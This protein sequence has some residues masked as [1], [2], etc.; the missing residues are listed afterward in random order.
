MR[1]HRMRVL[2]VGLGAM[3]EPM[4]RRLVGDAQVSVYDVAQDRREAVAAAIGAEVV[5]DP[6]LVIG[7][8]EVVIL[9]LPNSDIVDQV[10]S[11][12][13][14]A[15]RM[16]AGT[17]VVDMGSSDPFRTRELA[18]LLQEHGVDLVDAPVSGGRARA[19]SG[20]LTIMTGGSAVAKETVAPLL[21]AL[22]T[23]VIDV[24]VTGNGHAM[25][26]LN[27]LLS[28]TGLLAA[29]EVIA[30]GQRFGLTPETML[31][32]INASTGRNH[33][34]QVK[35]AE[36]ILSRRFDAGFAIGLMVKDLNTAGSLVDRVLPEGNLLSQVIDEW[37]QAL[38]HLEDGS[39]DH[40]AVARWVETVSGA[41][42]TADASLGV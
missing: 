13:G 19:I 18:A 35:F 5:A 3:G 22:G 15:A 2:V 12:S 26:A 7:D 23:S 42:L 6:S 20:E 28:A 36:F 24:G 25:K 14:L 30:S 41:Q 37:A 32:V 39:A 31:A 9:M 4:A 1:T 11:G 40:T 17:V 38:E 21:R 8:F 16:R 34:T 27:N 29:C 33:A 10:L